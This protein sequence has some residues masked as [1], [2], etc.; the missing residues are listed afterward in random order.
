L[1]TGVIVIGIGTPWQA[2][3][4]WVNPLNDPTEQYTGNA[5]EDM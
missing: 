5:D 3:Y 4:A 1:A 2:F